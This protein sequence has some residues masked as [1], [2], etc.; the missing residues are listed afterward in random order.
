MVY[1][2]ISLHPRRFRNNKAK[3]NRRYADDA[4]IAVVD[5]VEIHSKSIL[6]ECKS[7]SNYYGREQVNATDAYRRRLEEKI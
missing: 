1:N 7:L 3:N 2:K 5:F 6:S 4:D